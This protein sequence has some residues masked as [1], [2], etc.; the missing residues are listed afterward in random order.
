[1]K[2]TF[3]AVAIITGIFACNSPA[4]QED[5]PAE[6]TAVKKTSNMDN[7]DYDKGLGLVAK[8]DCFSCHKL[9]EQSTG[10]SYAAVAA[11]YPNNDSTV[12]ILA[13]KIIKGGQ[14]NWGQV[15]MTPHPTLS[16]DDASTMVKYILLLKE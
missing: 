4:K 13:G 3:L 9:N 10:P 5:K 2:K 15:P 16:K 7:P 12:S 6:P 1:M 14:G 8:S 11:K